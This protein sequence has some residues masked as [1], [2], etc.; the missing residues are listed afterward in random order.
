MKISVLTPSFN[1]GKYIERAIKSVLMQ[2]YKN[3]EHIVS[4]GG[5]KDNTVSILDKYSHIRYI[6]EKDHGQ[7]D[8]MNKA[9]RV[10]SGE[11][12]VY[13]NA[14]DEFAPGAFK[15]V[16][17][18]FEENP[19]S[20]MIVGDLLFQDIESSV[21]RVPSPRYKDILQY[22]QNLFPNNPVSYFYK[23]K[24]QDEIG[25]FPVD[26]HYAMDIWFLLKVY[27]KFRVI[28][29]DGILGTFHS[30][31]NNKTAVVNTGVNL[32]RTI[33]MHLRNENP[34]LLPF[35]YMKFLLARSRKAE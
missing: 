26:D 22:W 27:R 9:F 8:A 1:S 2:D 4:D 35:F 5:S 7:S 21:V 14:D 16:L 10:S 17:K 15:R 29:I 3:F 28:K 18:A 33:K 31:G 34:L 12:I 23:R 20:D 24:V 25:E 32:H 13:L 19:E 6:S 11:I 30:D